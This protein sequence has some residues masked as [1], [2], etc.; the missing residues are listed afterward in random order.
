MRL[1]IFGNLAKNGRRLHT[2]QIFERLTMTFG[3]TDLNKTNANIFY[4]QFSFTYLCI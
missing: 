2:L 1:K 3:C 4:F